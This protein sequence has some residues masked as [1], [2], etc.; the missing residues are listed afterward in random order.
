MQ[1]AA[2][3]TLVALVA[4]V[5]CSVPAASPAHA[6][7]CHAARA[8]PSDD[9]SYVW[10]GLSCASDPS[11]RRPEDQTPIEHRGVKYWCHVVTDL[12]MTPRAGSCTADRGSVRALSD[13]RADAVRPRVTATTVARLVALPRPARL[14]ARGEGAES[15]RYRVR[16]RLVRGST[17][18]A[19]ELRVVLAD[20]AG[21]ASLEARFPAQACTMR[22]HDAERR[23]IAAARAQLLRR[24]PALR[25]GRPQQLHGTATVVGVGFFAPAGRVSP[26]G[27][28]LAPVLAFAATG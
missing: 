16:A 7:P 9:H 2:R 10:S 23:A 1:P 18:P 17:G 11:Q 13:N 15:T 28:A 14:G 22:A 8:C 19:G 6:D 4:A 25:A 26:N 27:L 5:A 20:P 3:W 12:Q 24:F 21:G